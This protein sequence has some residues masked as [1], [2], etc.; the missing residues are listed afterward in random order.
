MIDD[1]ADELTVIHVLET[2]HLERR[3]LVD[4]QEWSDEEQ[5]AVLASCLKQLQRAKEGLARRATQSERADDAEVQWVVIG[6]GQS[7]NEAFADEAEE[8]FE[9]QGFD[10]VTLLLDRDYFLMD[11]GLESPCHL[12]LEG[13]TLRFMECAKQ[14]EGRNPALTRSGLGNALIRLAEGRELLHPKGAD[15]RCESKGAASE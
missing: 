12:I 5:Q 8:F 2:R 4:E 6:V 7:V 10:D 9:E 15:C 11:H 3:V 14:P 13:R 1:D